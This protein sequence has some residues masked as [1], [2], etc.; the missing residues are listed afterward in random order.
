MFLRNLYER[1]TKT[2]GFRNPEYIKPNLIIYKLH[3][4]S[5]RTF[6]YPADALFLLSHANILLIPTISLI[7]NVSV[8]PS[9]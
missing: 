5:L 2:T 4:H 8:L 1:E 6:L 7:I 3:S 9:E